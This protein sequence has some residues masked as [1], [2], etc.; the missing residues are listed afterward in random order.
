MRYPPHPLTSGECARLLD[1]CGGG[2]S[3]ARN[4]ALLVL[5]YRAGLRCTEACSLDV[6]DLRRVSGGLVVRVRFPKG[7]QRKQNPAPPREV[8]LDPKAQK[9]VEAWADTWRR[10]AE[11][12]LL[13]TKSGARLLSSYVRTLLPRLAHKAGIRRRVH[14]HAL[15]HTFARELYDEGAGLMEIMLALG[16]R[17]LDTTQTYLQSI[18][19]TEVIDVTTRREW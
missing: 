7:W 4:R 19:A 6:G 5:G 3:G 14:F 18:G 13:T 11:G 2:R 10:G 16:H 9:I 1:A 12:P 15:R 8:G 17:R